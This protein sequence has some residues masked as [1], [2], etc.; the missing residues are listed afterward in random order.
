LIHPNKTGIIG[1]LKF[2]P[3]GKRVIA[4]DY[5]G[6]VIALW[7][8]ATGKRLTTLE[9]GYGY[10]STAKYFSVAPDWQTVYVSREKRNYERV[11]Q[12]GKRMIHWTF[13]GDIRAWGLKDGGLLRTYKHKP[14]R[15]IRWM[16]LS[17]NGTKLL[18]VEHQSGT[19]EHG[20]PSTASLWDVQSGAYRP[21]D[22]L[23]N[24]GTFSPDGRTLAFTVTDAEGYAR[25]RKL[26][27]AATG[28]ERWSM[29]VEDKNTF[30]SAGAFSR[31]ARLLVGTVRVLD[32]PKKW[33]SWRSGMK[34]WDA[35]TGR[36]VASFECDNNDDLTNFCQSGDG[37]TLAALNWRGGKRQ[38]FLYS[39]PDKRQLR[40]VTL[41]EKTE[42]QRPIACSPVFSPDGK[43][44]AV[45]TRTYP[46]K[47]AG[48]D[49]D[50]RDVPQPRI[51][52]IETATGEVRETMI[53]PPAFANV[54]CFSPDGRTLATGGHGRVLLWDMTKMP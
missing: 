47:T 16:A 18:T 42:G 29:P 39:V 43:W 6:G 48:D 20:Y 27:D 10:R 37:Q 1:D 8:V 34:W 21:V 19:Y 22:G 23:Q 49:L 17:P 53:A 35:A 45:I 28:R 51:L 52:L 2:S 40:T 24:V 11:E 13:D 15:G 54:A 33:D 32:G 25:T 7:D 31:D 41:C 9:T 46:E 38:L 12:N 3:D 50:P 4:G 14:P 5:P 30:V 26:I 44:V 36:E